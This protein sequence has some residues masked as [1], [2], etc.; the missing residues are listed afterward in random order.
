MKKKLTGR[1][2]ISICE[3]IPR[4]VTLPHVATTAYSATKCSAPEIAFL[5]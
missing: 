5:I 2:S 3:L 1:L 4:K